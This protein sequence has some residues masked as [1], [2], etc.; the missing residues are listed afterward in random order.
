[1][2]KEAEIRFSLIILISF[3]IHIIVI[4]GIWLPIYD[5]I[6]KLKDVLD[7][8]SQARDI[9]VNINE[10]N[11]EITGKSTLLSEKDSSARGY[12]TKEKG[13]HWLNNSRDFVLQQGSGSAEEFRDDT[14][15]DRTTLLLSDNTELIITLFREEI[16]RLSGSR[17]TG[18]TIVKSK[19]TEFRIPDKNT[20]SRNNAIYYSSDG[21]FSFNTMK[22]KPFKYFKE[23]K[24]KIANHWYPPPL[25]NFVTYG[26]DPFTN[27]YTP[28]RFRIMAVPTQTVKLYFTMNRDGDVLDVGIIDSLGISFIDASCVDAIRLSKN[29]GRVPDELKGN[30]VVIPFAFILLVQ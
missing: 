1:M 20:F 17:Q 19:E 22:F 30:V 9:I 14:D 27:S 29:F 10:D 12:I 4:L 15:A 11:K 24:D 28:G 7:R 25:A 16:Q 26:Y 21:N 8:S 23:M 18:K 13:S 3:F 2:E 5:N 6:L